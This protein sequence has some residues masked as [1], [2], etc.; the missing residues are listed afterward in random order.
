MAEIRESK[1]GQWRMEA[2]PETQEA[3][4]RELG[5]LLANLRAQGI[6]AAIVELTCGK[7]ATKVVR[8]NPESSASDMAQKAI[9]DYSSDQPDIDRE[10]PDDEEFGVA[11]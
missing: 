1:A 7:L 10:D 8:P 3:S 6:S 5:E 4:V 9:A 11:L 2:N